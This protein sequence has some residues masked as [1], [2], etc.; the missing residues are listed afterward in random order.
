[1]IILELPIPVTVNKLTHNNSRTGGRSKTK[2]AR[3]WTRLARECVLDVM[4]AHHTTVNSNLAVR[5]KFWEFGKKAYN[6]HAM[7][8]ENPYLS[9][10]VE[11]HYYF[12]EK[13]A[14][15]P[16]DIFNYEKQLTDFIV[17]CG[18]MLDDSFLDEGRVLRAEPDPDN[19][20]V[21]IFIKTL[22]RK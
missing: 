7:H 2:H 1:M 4:R 15:L 12:K 20:R 18:F 8:K 10:M 17:D 19:P 21:K 16:R 5:A 3:N 9:Y 13:R 14:A 6:L 11:Y 22:D